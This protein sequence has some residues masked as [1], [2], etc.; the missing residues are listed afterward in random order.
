MNEERFEELVGLLLDE[1]I[2]GE[3]LNELS[4]MVAED[5]ALL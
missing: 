5:P 2:A 4:D 1:E 3:E